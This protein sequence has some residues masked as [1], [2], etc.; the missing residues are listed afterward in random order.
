M[1]CLHHC[2]ATAVAVFAG[3]G[4]AGQGR[5]G[6]IRTHQG[7]AGWGRAGQGRTGQ[8]RPSKAGHWRDLSQRHFTHNRHH[9]CSWSSIPL[10]QQTGCQR[11]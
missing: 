1:R 7:R 11:Q 8:G 10:H 3:Q 9:D 5:A 6:Q 2:I 4:R